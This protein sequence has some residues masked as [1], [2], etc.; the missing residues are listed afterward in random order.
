MINKIVFA[1]GGTGGH[2]YP[3]IA[4]ADEMKKINENIE[5]KFIGAKGRIEEKIVPQN[6][7]E[8][9]TIDISGFKRSLSYKNILTGIKTIKALGLSKQILKDFNPDV[10]FG[11]GGFVSGPVLKSAR[12]LK[13]PI[14]VQEGNFYPGV[15]VKLLSPVADKVILNFKGSKKFLKRQD[16]IEV[17]SYPVRENLKRYDKSEALRY[18]GLDSNKKTLFVFGGSQGA[19][20][21]NSAIVKCFKNFVSAGVQIIWQTGESDFESISNE[22]SNQAGVKVLEYIDAIDYA[23]SGADLVLCR[24]GISTIM[25]LASFGSAVIFV[26]YPEA[27]ENHQEKNARAIVEKNA[28]EIILDKDLNEK[29]ESTVLNLINSSIKLDEMRANIK[30]FADV[31]AASKIAGLLIELVNSLKN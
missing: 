14:V 28:A 3:A 17:I 26:P 2:I 5:I 20:S 15:T 4:V 6:G 1:T 9:E 13:I 10:V 16:N 19:K 8:L 21:I 25:E 31:K 29:L 7:Y 23:Y 12:R 27:S 11:T 22:V 24:A 30:Q 18:F